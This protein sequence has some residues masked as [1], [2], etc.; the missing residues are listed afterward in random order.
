M[1]HFIFE[2]FSVK[3]LSRIIKVFNTSG[4]YSL[5][6]L[7]E[8]IWLHFWGKYCKQGLLTDFEGRTLSYGPSFLPSAKREGKKSKGKNEDP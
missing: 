8:L 5:K 4:S 3:L 2:T 7:T 6:E 1:P